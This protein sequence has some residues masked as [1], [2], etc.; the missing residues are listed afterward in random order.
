MFKNQKEVKLPNRCTSL[1]FNKSIDQFVVSDGNIIKVYNNSELSSQNP[2]YKQKIILSN[3]VICMKYN[4]EGSLLAVSDLDYRLNVFDTENFYSEYSKFNKEVL[5]IWNLDFSP[6]NKEIAT[7]A[8]S[9]MI[10]DVKTKERIHD[11]N[12]ENNYIY[13]LCYLDNQKIATGNANGLISVYDVEKNKRLARLEG[14]IYFILFHK[15][16]Y[17]LTEINIDHCLRVR[18]LKFDAQSNFLFSASDDLHINIIDPK[19]F[20]VVQ[21]LVGH[22]D[23]I[24]NIAFN[25][26]Y[27]IFSTCSLDGVIKFW[28]LRNNSGKCIQTIETLD[29]SIIWDSEFSPDGKHLIAGAFKFLFFTFLIILL[30]IYRY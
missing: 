19:T 8:Y 10:F 5:K 30:I 22:K 11:I 2:D 1:T 13:S 27:Q 29:G 25:N 6:N 23:C 14:I 9:L 12:N 3:D 7:G 17:C 28:D 21:P 4:N 20:K 16:I 18:S 24:T 26:F 15:F